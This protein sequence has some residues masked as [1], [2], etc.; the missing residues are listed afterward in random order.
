M[1][2]RMRTIGL[3]GMVAAL[4]LA[5]CGGDDD[6]PT[7]RPVATEVPATATPAPTPAPTS[8]PTPKPEASYVDEVVVALG[9]FPKDL[10]AGG[11]TSSYDGVSPLYDPLWEIDDT[12]A[13]ETGVIEWGPGIV[14]EWEWSGGF[15]TLRMTLRKGVQAHE[16]W[17][18]YTADEA[19]HAFNVFY[20][21]RTAT[22]G[23]YLNRYDVLAKKLGD[24]EF[25]ISTA[26]GSS[27]RPT[28]RILYN[29]TVAPPVKAF[30]ESVGM[31][32]AA[33]DP[34]GATGP[35]RLVRKSVG[36]I[37]Y[38]AV[39]DH[40]RVQPTSSRLRMEHVPESSV[41]MAAVETGRAHVATR[42]EPVDAVRAKNRGLR[43]VEQIG[44]NAVLNFGGAQSLDNRGDAPWIENKLVRKAIAMAIDAD[45]IRDS[46]G[47]GLGTRVSTIYTTIGS[48]DN[49]PYPYNPTEAKRL[50]TEAGFPF[51]KEITMP[52][53]VIGGAERAGPEHRAVA[54]LLEAVGLNVKIEVVDWGAVWRPKWESGDTDW[55]LWV[56]T[57]TSFIGEPLREWLGATE[58]AVT[59]YWVDEQTVPLF[60]AMS[61]ALSRAGGNQQDVA[62]RQAA[63]ELGN[64]AYDNYIMVPIYTKPMLF[65][66][67]NQVEAWERYGHHDATRY[68]LIKVRVS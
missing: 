22:T 31:D 15:S 51:E 20:R 36:S 23:V 63:T 13:A 28:W 65:V 27:F 18:E 61:D 8:T 38:E 49:T 6:T 43:L 29:N 50:L 62:F 64:Y 55:N 41:R 5:A 40:W 14:Q 52:L 53:V 33:E 21:A 42:V 56:F 7:P 26:D 59:T 11:P 44:W 17:G 10:L 54:G 46:V 12:K 37:D 19:V 35:Y 24:Y 3:L 57:N 66:L 60:D 25:E 48:T 58:P 2:L 1:R 4:A 16:G 47:A 45:G 34:V 39:P 68:D 9:R 32:G 67:G 30:I